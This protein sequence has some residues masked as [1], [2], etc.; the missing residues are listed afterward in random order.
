MIACSLPLTR[1]YP[2]IHVARVQASALSLHP[3]ECRV[4]LVLRKTTQ[5]GGKVSLERGK[6]QQ[7]ADKTTYQWVVLVPLLGDALHVLVRQELELGLRH[8]GQGQHSEH[9]SQALHGSND[10]KV[11]VCSD[12]ATSLKPPVDQNRT[13]VIFLGF[14]VQNH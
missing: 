13:T 3:H 2:G 1:T 7:R 11:A 5:T 14:K 10:A 12:V 9:N 4:I 8:S 6:S